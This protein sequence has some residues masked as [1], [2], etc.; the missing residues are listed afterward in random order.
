[1]EPPTTRRRGLSFRL[2][3]AF[4]AVSIFAFVGH[5]FLSGKMVLEHMSQ[6][7]Y[8]GFP[9]VHQLQA[10]RLPSMRC[11]LLSMLG[12]SSVI[13]QSTT[14]DQ[15]IATEYP[16]AKEGLLANIGPSGSKCLGAKASVSRQT[17]FLAPHRLSS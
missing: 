4:V 11:T 7:L 13:F 12:L 9:I 15:Y 14:V 10:L 8:F 3:F 5:L 6:P 2:I 17:G 1:M 16:I